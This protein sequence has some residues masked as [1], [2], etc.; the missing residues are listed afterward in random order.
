METIHAIRKG[1][2]KTRADILVLVVSLV[3]FFFGV[4]FSKV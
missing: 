2:G 3:F 1:Q 4:T